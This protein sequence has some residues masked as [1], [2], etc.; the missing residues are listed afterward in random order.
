MR[1]LAKHWISAT[2]LLLLA[3]AAPALANPRIVAVGDLHGDHAAFV[4]IASSAI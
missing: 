2:L 3:L 1:V 4:A